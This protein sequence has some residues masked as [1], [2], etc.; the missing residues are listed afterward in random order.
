[1]IKSNI[2]E[3]MQI[4]GLKTLGVTVSGTFEQIGIQFFQLNKTKEAVDC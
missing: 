3:I 2:T 1:M 4:V